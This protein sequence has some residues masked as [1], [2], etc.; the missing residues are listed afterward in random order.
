[1]ASLPEQD[2]QEPGKLRT[3]SREGKKGEPLTLLQATSEKKLLFKQFVMCPRFI[4][5]CWWILQDLASL[6][7][8]KRFSSSEL[9]FSSNLEIFQLIKIKSATIFDNYEKC[10]VAIVAPVL[11]G[12]F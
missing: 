8:C 6:V 5:P 10:Q 7:V 11:R 2:P 4:L 12:R 3:I 1:M 9:L